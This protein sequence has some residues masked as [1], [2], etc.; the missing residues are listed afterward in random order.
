MGDTFKLLYQGQLTITPAVLYT[1]P[2]FAS[3]I[4]KHIRVTNP[5][6][7]PVSFRMW[8]SGVTDADLIVP[9]ATILA[10]GWAEFDGSILAAASDTIA[11][12]AS[13][14]TSLTITIY[15]DEVTV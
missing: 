9:A 4:I 13:A 1:V 14:N 8:Q 2:A 7:G 12:S 6:G 15:G 10:G 3:C 5:T 11:G